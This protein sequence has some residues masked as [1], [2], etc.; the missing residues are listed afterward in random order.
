MEILKNFGGAESRHGG[1]GRITLI[2]SGGTAKVM[3]SG[4]K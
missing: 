2:R 1:A 3:G 4:S